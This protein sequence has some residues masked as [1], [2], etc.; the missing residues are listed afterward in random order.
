MKD[1]ITTVP[2]PK[3]VVIQ[4]LLEYHV[5]LSCPKN[6]TPQVF[7]ERVKEGFSKEYKIDVLARYYHS[8][9]KSDVMYEVQKDLD[10][11]SF[12]KKMEELKASGGEIIEL[13]KCPDDIL[14][15]SEWIKNRI[16][17]PDFKRKREE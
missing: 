8:R 12:K 6:A 9:G 7:R 2:G 11:P 3:H 17:I 5:L 1:N 13:D 16:V 14:L 10:L 15:A 4:A